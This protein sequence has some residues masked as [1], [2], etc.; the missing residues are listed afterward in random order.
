MEN[1]LESFNDV[2]SHEEIQLCLTIAKENKLAEIAL[3]EYWENIKNPPPPELISEDKF[4]SIVIEKAKSE[5]P[6]F[7]LSQDEERIYR[8]LSLYFTNTEEFEAMGDDFSL[9]KGLVLY[10]NVGCG[11]TTALKLFS[12]NPRQSFA[13]ISCIKVANEFSKHG[14]EAVEKFFGMLVSGVPKLTYGQKELGICFDDL[15]T[16]SKK[17]HFGEEANVMEQII[18]SRYDSKCPTHMT[19][20]LSPDQIEEFYGARVRSR[21]REMFNVIEFPIDSRDKR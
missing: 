13:V 15:G 6:K 1:L 17:K 14:I 9:N 3:K 12:H 8:V 5:I 18:L 16:E 19:T 21:M 7:S 11:K 10:G 20:N 2:L 4:Y